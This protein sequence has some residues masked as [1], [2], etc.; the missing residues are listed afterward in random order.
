M[1]TDNGGGAGGG[2]AGQGGGCE[3]ELSDSLKTFGAVLKALREEARLT[4]E[5]LAPLVQYSVAYIAKIEQGRRFPP[6]NLLDRSE[7]ALGAVAGRVLA[8]AAR[9]LTRKVGLASWFRQWAAIE[10]E[11]V[12]L[13]AYEC[14]AIPG[15]LQPEAYIRA[16]FERRL[17]PLSEDQ[18]EYQVT[19]RLERQQL[20]AEKPN[21]AFSFIIE[22]ALLERHMGGPEVARQLLDHL[23]MRGV[24][25]NV[26]IQVMPTRMYDHAGIDGLMYLAETPRHEWVGYSEG[27]QSSNLITA[28]KDVSAMLQRYGKLRSQALD[29]EATVSLLEQM[30]G[31][32]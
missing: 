30:R 29:R 3:P 4:Q 8:A 28:P 31:A 20:L 7:E 5:Q 9:S 15:L 19:A 22:Q 13:Y 26:E 21:T 11:A 16:I 17:P 23:L 10:E 2:G 32:L 25:R 6:R 27:Q 12:S 18:I 14:R 24:R 1:A